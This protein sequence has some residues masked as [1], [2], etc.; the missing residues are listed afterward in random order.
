MQFP[1]SESCAIG[2]RVWG[3]CL[4]YKLVLLYKNRLRTQPR[5]QEREVSEKTFCDGQKWRRH[6]GADMM[7]D[8]SG[9]H[10]VELYIYDLTQGMATMM[11]SAFLGKCNGFFWKF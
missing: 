11:S 10:T 1:G 5:H 9:A 6:K 3:I 8:D 2:W 7:A 4:V